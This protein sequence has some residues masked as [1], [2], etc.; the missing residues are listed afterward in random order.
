MYLSDK[1]LKDAIEKGE[2]LCSPPPT[3]FDPTSI[4]LH[5]DQ[6]HEARIWGIDKYVADEA[7][8]GSRRPELRIGQYKYALF[9]E[10]YLSSPPAYD[11]TSAALVQLRS[12]QGNGCPR[13]LFPLGRQ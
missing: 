12:N 5:L 3:T 6:V 11:D 7:I 10:K 9:A 13:G 1:D 4:D 2:L 8:R